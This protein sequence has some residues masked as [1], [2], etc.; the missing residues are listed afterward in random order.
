VVVQE[1]G[2]V[3]RVKNSKLFLA[4]L[5]FPIFLLGALVVFKGYKLSSGKKFTVPIEAYDPRD[6]L[7]GHFLRFKISFEDKDPCYSPQAS[8]SLDHYY[9]LSTG[10]F[11]TSNDLPICEAWLAGTC[12]SGSFQTGLDRFYVPENDAKF[13]EDMLRGKKA[14]L[15]L[16]VDPQGKAMIDD[17]LIDGESWRKKVSTK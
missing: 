15:V 3:D 4:A 8:D 2:G 13:L 11:I 12:E 6:L 17:L 7:S 16:S 1:S 14:S 9:C 5:L 10:K